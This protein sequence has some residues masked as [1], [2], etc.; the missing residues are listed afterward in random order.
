MNKEKMDLLRELLED[1]RRAELRAKGKETRIFTEL[2]YMKIDLS[3]PT[4][5]ENANNLEE[6]ICC[7]IQYGEYGIENILREIQS[8]SEGA[9]T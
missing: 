2:E 7:Y 3:L 4:N 9:R 8:A 5:A 6:A 1:A